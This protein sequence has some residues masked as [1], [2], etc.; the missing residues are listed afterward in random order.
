MK[1][2][3]I[4]YNGKTY[5]ISRAIGVAGYIF[6]LDSNKLL[7]LANKR[8]AGTPDYQGYWNC[9]CG[10]LDFDETTREACAREIMEETNLYVNPDRLKL[11]SIEDEPTANKQNVTFRYWDFSPVLYK[12]QTVF[13]KGAEQNEVSDVEWIDIDDLD[14]YE[15][16]F[17]QKK[18]IYDIILT[19]LT[20]FIS[21][22]T[23]L[24]IEE[25]T[26]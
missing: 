14:K 12:G 22:E 21:N 4:E 19:H 15:F 26:Q 1:N 23:L 2:F 20:N 13:P 11:F 17:N 8:G 5:W 25:C 6:C 10:Y 18:T 16:A 7:I 24:K 9:P 3:P